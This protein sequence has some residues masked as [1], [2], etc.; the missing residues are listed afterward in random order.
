MKFHEAEKLTPRAV[1]HTIDDPVEKQQTGLRLDQFLVH[2]LPHFSRTTIIHSIRKGLILVDGE[3]KKGSY[4][5]KHKERV[6]GSVEEKEQPILTAQDVAFTI[7]YEDTS[8]LVISKPPGLVVHPAPGNPDKTLVNGLVYYYQQLETVGDS[9]RP[10]I[11]HRLDKDTS[12]IMVVAKTE[13]VHRDLINQFKESR[14]G[15]EYLALVHG[16]LPDDHGRIVEPIGRHPV[17]RQKMS[18]RRVGGKHAASNYTV[19]E[20]YENRFSL[21]KVGIET[22]RTHQIRVHMAYL[23]HPIV[24]DTVYGSARHSSGFTR[25]LLHAFRLTFAHPEFGFMTKV[26]PLWPDFGS[27]LAGFG[28]KFTQGQ[29]IP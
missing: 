12:G 16:I 29:E 6:Q 5:L 27:V 3:K 28:S 18:V 26:A 17:N 2:R 14:V 1:V 9:L 23:G 7:L 8:V 25:Q 19:L 22:G 24:G 20:Q 10:G 4:R 15:K 13:A 11:V 21:L